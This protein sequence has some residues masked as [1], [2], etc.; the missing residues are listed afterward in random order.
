MSN[1]ANYVDYIDSMLSDTHGV[2]T[3]DEEENKILTE[4]EYN[5]SYYNIFY[6]DYK[7]YVYSKHVLFEYIL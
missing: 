1:K 7:S 5:Y 6:D 4:T 3:S 2:Y